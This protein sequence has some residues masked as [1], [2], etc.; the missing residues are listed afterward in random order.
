MIQGFENK[1]IGVVSGGYSLERP[2]SLRSGQNVTEALNRLGYKTIEIDPITNLSK[3]NEIDI[4]F[5]VLHGKGGEDGS[6]QGL[7]DCLNIPYTGSGATS[8]ALALN[9]VYTKMCLEKNGFPV[10][11][12]M[13]CSEPLTVLPETFSYPVVIKPIDDG[14]SMG[15]Y[16]VDTNEELLEKSTELYG[17]YKSFLLEKFVSGREITIGV[18]E[19]KSLI[20]LPILELKSKNR[21]YDY[22][23]KYTPGMTTFICPAPI[24]PPLSEACTKAAL[25]IFSLLNCKGIAR[26]DMFIQESSFVV[27]EVNTL[28]GMTETSDLPEQA[29]VAGM[30]FDNLVETLLQTAC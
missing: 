29:K 4:A 20:T 5:L 7:L 11:P 18:L 10:C 3:L 26:I 12:Y 23:A 1:T 25:E 2:V 27:Q 13:V 6:I 22:E 9:K 21:I 8:S 30:S 17:I 16:V 24:S 14:S 28:P 19:G 15:V